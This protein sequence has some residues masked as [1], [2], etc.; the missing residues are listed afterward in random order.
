MDDFLPDVVDGRHEP[1]SL[2]AQHDILD[3]RH[4]LHQHEVLVDH[5]DSQVDGIARRPDVRPPAMHMDFAG[6]CP[7]QAGQDVH[8]GA[9][10][11]AVFAQQRVDFA[12]PHFEI[13]VV[14]GDN[15]REALDDAV[16]E[17]RG[18]GCSLISHPSIKLASGAN[19]RSSCGGCQPTIA[20]RRRASTMLG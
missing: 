14:A 12:G 18:G 9:L 10:A 1:D 19:Q 2:Q 4:G 8:Q 15:A 13:D 3:D 17:D 20:Q 5:A 16:H 7:V 6:I 11:G